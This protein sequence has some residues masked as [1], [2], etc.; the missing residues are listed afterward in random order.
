MSQRVFS[1]KLPSITLNSHKPAGH[2]MIGMVCIDHKPDDR[3]MEGID[4]AHINLFNKHG[5]YTTVVKAFGCS[6]LCDSRNRLAAQ[7]Y[8]TPDFTKCLFIDSDV[9]FEHGTLERLLLHPVDLV[10]GAY[11]KRGD[12]QGFPIKAFPGPMEVVDPL[13]GAQDIKNGLIKI[14][15]GG[16]GMMCISRACITRMVEH[17]DDRWYMHAQQAAKKA[18]NLFEFTV[19]DHE[20]RSEDI[21]FCQLWRNLGGDV[22]CD[23]HLKLHHIGE[24]AYSEVF[25][26]HLKE[27]GRVTD[28]GKVAKMPV[29]RQFTMADLIR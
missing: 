4:V 9:A 29:G 22:W 16:A 6:D 13:T 27:V 28:L 21:N 8:D 15:G 25:L 18:W 5:W 12:G 17:Y 10:L 11:Q 24:K 23:P 26:E 7:F 1:E 14:A 2:V 3:V 19:V 20:R